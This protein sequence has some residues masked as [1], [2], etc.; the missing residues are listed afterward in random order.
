M[1]VHY[2]HSCST[3]VCTCLLTACVCTLSDSVYP[4]TAVVAN[5]MTYHDAVI[6][7]RCSS[8]TIRVTYSISNSFISGMR[9]VQHLLH[10]SPRALEPEAMNAIHLDCYN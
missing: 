2:V 6:M 1:I 8:F 10:R 3:A 7:E 4:S 9:D 5:L